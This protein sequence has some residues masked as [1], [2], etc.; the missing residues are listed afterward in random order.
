MDEIG[1]F[2]RT[3]SIFKKIPGGVGVYTFLIYILIVGLFIF[4]INFIKVEDELELSH[5]IAQ[6]GSGIEMCFKDRNFKMSKYEIISLKLV[7]IK[8]EEIS[9]IPYN[10]IPF[11]VQKE[12]ITFLIDPKDKSQL[13]RKI[14][15]SD[16]A[17]LIVSF[18]L[19]NILKFYYGF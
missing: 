7:N 19:W 13:Y 12:C 11:P 14:R 10:S 8:K 3:S 15:E 1:S 16:K 17:F 4:L 2:N 18:S 5:N 6:T 9:I